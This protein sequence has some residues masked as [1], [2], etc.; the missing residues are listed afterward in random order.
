MAFLAI[1]GVALS[2]TAVAQED[3]YHGDTEG[4]EL[5]VEEDT[6]DEFAC[7][8]AK[9]NN[10]T[11][12]TGG[13]S[14]EDAPTVSDT[15]VVWNVTYSG[16]E[17][18]VNFDAGSHT[19]D[20]PYV[21]YAA[22]GSVDAV[23]ANGSVDAVD[24]NGSVD[25]VDA[26][27][28]ER[29]G[30]PGCDALDEYVKIEAPED[31]VNSLVLTDVG[32]KFD[33]LNRSTGGVVAEAHG[34]RWYGNISEIVQGEHVSLGANV[35][36]RGG[37]EIEPDGGNHSLGVEP[38][39]GAD[40]NVVSLEEHGDYV[41]ITG[42]EEGTAEVLF[43]LLHNDSIEYETPPMEVSVVQETDEVREEPNEGET[44]ETVELIAE[45]EVDNEHA[46]LH[47]DHDDRVPLTGGDSAGGAPTVE[48]D[49]VIWNV[50]HSDG[51]YVNFDA[52]GYNN[53]GQF[54]FYVAGGSANPTESRVIGKGDVG[55]CDSLD[56]Y[57]EVEVPSDEVVTLELTEGDISS[58]P[59]DEPAP[60][61]ENET[62]EE[63]SE[64]VE[65]LAEKEVDNEHACLHGDHDGRT[66]LAGGDSADSAPT[67][68]EDHVI[69]NVTH[70]DGGYV[71][72]D[73]GGYNDDGQFVFYVAGGSANPT[74]SRVIG[75]GDVGECDSL[76]GYIEVE[77]PSDEVITLELT[78]GDISSVPVDEPAPVE[79]N[80]TEEEK[81][82]QT[83]EKQEPEVETEET[84]ER[85]AIELLAEKEVNHEHACLH[86]GYDDRVPLTGGDSAEDAPVINETHVTWNVTHHGEEGY[87]SFDTEPY[88]HNGSFVFYTADGS[89][90]PVGSDIAGNGNVGECESLEEYI[91]V[92]KPSDGVISLQLVGESL[93]APGEESEET[94][95]EGG[96]QKES[97]GES[98]E[99]HS[100]NEEV[101]EANE[102]DENEN[103]ESGTGN[104]E[105]GV[106]S[107]NSSA[108]T[109]D[110]EDGDGDSG[111]GLP[112]FTGLAALVALSVG[113]ALRRR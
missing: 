95:G 110:P 54:V 36:D 64:T 23:D 90:E 18:Y 74:S 38:A 85:K 60:V 83:E 40:E 34:E 98:R 88:D 41:R 50:T 13:A 89:A 68:E 2:G 56:G 51:G 86:G 67:V 11:S 73:A 21:F 81:E 8:Y 101:D 93:N 104:G 22:N 78:E 94:E 47:G 49:H 16:D 25:A 29:G 76:D 69:W 14:V 42:E 77:T 92:E 30:V 72:F 79:E 52:G 4:V 27:V 84:G 6:D 15:H 37:N 53:D 108:G 109:S 80:E 107:E 28:L 63:K 7:V 91:K 111:E 55:E 17:G 10:R 100:E 97:V 44:P 58:V 82:N 103:A 59:V 57:I 70:G 45:K 48:E 46:C 113:V 43:Q 62:E 71:N 66:P 33:I 102:E 32:Y 99:E 65:L 12:L 35:E 61:E 105:D 87:V 75:K 19:A 96:T 5:L 112:G 106:M 20:A 31:G 9:Y 39:G 24:A 1:A 26:E 3:A